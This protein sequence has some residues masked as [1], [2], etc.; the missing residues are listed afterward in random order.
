M[1]LTTTPCF[2]PLRKRVSPWVLISL[3][4][5]SDVMRTLLCF[6]RI[7]SIFHSSK[8]RS[9]LMEMVGKLDILHICQNGGN[10]AGC[11]QVSKYR[12]ACVF[13]KAFPGSN[14]HAQSAQK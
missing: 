1:E 5:L 6:N 8:V 7:E 14:S 10:F 2:L 3:G 13:L 11:R 9:G 4:F 12:S